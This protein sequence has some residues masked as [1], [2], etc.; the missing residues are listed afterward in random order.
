MSSIDNLSELNYIFNGT[1][2]TLEN[3]KAGL[4]TFFNKGNNKQEIFNAM[5]I[6]LR[7]SLNMDDF[8]DL[9]SDKIDQI[10]NIIVKTK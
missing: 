2:L 1:K 7:Q 5:S 8:L 3:A 9:T 6:D 10:I 4:K